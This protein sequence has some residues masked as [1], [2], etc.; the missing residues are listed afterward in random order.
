MSN[1]KIKATWV[2][3]KLVARLRDSLGPR[4][5]QTGDFSS[6]WRADPVVKILILITDAPPGEFNDVK[7]PADVQ[8]MHDLALTALGRNILVSDIFVPTTGDYDGQLAIL[9]DDA[10]TSRGA[11]TTTAQNGTGTAGAIKEIIANC[12]EAPPTGICPNENVQHWDKI[13]FSIKNRDLAEKLNLT[14]NTELDIKVLY[15]PTSVADIKQKVL[16]FLNAP[17]CASRKSV[18]ILDVKYA[19]SY[20]APTPSVPPTKLTSESISLMKSLTEEKRPDLDMIRQLQLSN[21]T[22]NTTSAAVMISISPVG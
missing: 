13:V 8:R 5:G 1:A 10:D 21:S 14:A 19:I 17:Y 3:M 12:G 7:D 6:P 15:Y 20:S 11:F 22:G 9:K 16:D 2:M 4:P 18:V